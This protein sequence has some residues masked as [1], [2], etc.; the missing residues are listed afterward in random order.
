[1]QDLRA[2]ERRGGVAVVGCVVR[3]LATVPL[4][5]DGIGSDRRRIPSG[6]GVRVAGRIDVLAIVA[7]ALRH[8]MGE[9]TLSSGRGSVPG[10]RIV[11]AKVRGRVVRTVQVVVVKYGILVA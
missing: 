5:A 11:P 6:D 2:A 10:K 1:M 8:V 3:G 4:G 7:S 9:D